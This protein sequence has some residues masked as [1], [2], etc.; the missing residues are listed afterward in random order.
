MI[1]GA[2]PVPMTDTASVFL[3]LPVPAVGASSR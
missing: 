3:L 1:A 2:T